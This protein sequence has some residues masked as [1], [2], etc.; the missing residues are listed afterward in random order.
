VE[1]DNN[2]G[3]NIKYILQQWPDQ[4]Y[5]DLFKIALQNGEYNRM[6]AAVAYA[7]VGGVK[8]LERIFREELDTKR[9]NEINKQWL[10]G[11]DWCRSDPPALAQLAAFKR[12]QVKIPNGQQI[13]SRSGCFPNKTYHPKLYIFQGKD[14]SAIICGS[15]NLSA[16]GLTKGCECGSILFVSSSRNPELV[17]LLR[18]FRTAWKEAN[19][20]SELKA[21]YVNRCKQLLKKTNKFFPTEDDLTPEQFKKRVQKKSLSEL[22]IRQLRTFDNFWIQAGA[23]G[24]NLGPGK[25][26]NQLDM[27]RYTRV[28]FGFPAV[29]VAPN[30]TIGF[31]T[32]VWNGMAHSD[33]TLKFGNNGMDK[34]NVPPSGDYGPLFYKNKT[35]LFTRNVD[36]SFLFTVGTN[37]NCAKWRRLSNQLNANYT[38]Q[39]GGRE[40]GLF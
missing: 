14:V 8:V 22:Q 25:P 20:Y 21:V 15:G 7:T 9:W 12:S 19:P 31:V 27:T 28:F 5:A 24:A 26:G 23:L 32:L 29:D 10:V 6:F 33:R 1:E 3:T 11:I 13:I 16:S 39:P 35:F 30:T 38:M 4:Q 40:W 34:L 36:G 2:R 17:K 18:W 37:T